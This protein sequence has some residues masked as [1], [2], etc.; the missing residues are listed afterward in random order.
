[1]PVMRLSRFARCIPGDA[2]DHDNWPTWVSAG[3]RRRLDPLVR[4]ACA[5]LE[6]LQQQGDPLP[7]DSAVI[8]ATAYGAVESTFRFA[9]S[10][11]TYG[12]SGASPTPFTTSVHNSCAAA[13]GELL[14]FR[15]PTSTISHGPAGP[16]I[17]LRFASQ[18]IASGRAPAAIVLAGERHNEWSRNVVGTLSQSP[19]PT[20]DGLI[21]TVVENGPG[22]GRELFF[23]PQPTDMVIDGGYFSSAEEAT[24]NKIC[25]TRDSAP[26]FLS[27]WWPGCGLAA[28]N[29]QSELRYQIC[30]VE[31]QRVE[32]VW[33]GPHIKH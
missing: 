29:W 2:V 19:W 28:I 14:H 30:E 12:D 1:M 4:M 23:T 13:L 31:H 5:A 10:M 6:R 17:A 20:G 24:L 7:Q 25:I 21:A 16:I 3:S 26:K 33:L 15:G 8:V 18:L 27:K 11:A 22:P 32:S 9:T